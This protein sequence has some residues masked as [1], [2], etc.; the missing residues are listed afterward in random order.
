MS[1]NYKIAVIGDKD[2]VTAFKVLGLNAFICDDPADAK[3]ILRELKR[4]FKDNYAVIYITE[5]LAAKL[6]DEVAAFR[7]IAVP[8]LIL[9]PSK[10]GS[11][12]LGLETLTA[13][14]ERATG[15][16]LF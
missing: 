15:T 6:P 11:L 9:I 10:G 16:K 4:G 12:G 2:S 13:A 3:Q 8:A 5:Q 14:A 1:D 7:E